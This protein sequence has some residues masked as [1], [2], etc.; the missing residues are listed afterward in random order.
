MIF[1]VSDLHLGREPDRDTAILSDLADC[2]STVS[3]DTVI[4]LGDV[5]DAF[6]ETPGRIP[7]PVHAWSGYVE[8]WLDE[9][10]DVRFVMGNHDRWHRE[11]IENLTGHT[12][13]RG[14]LDLDFGNHAVRL[15]HGD[16][17]EPHGPLTRFARWFSDLW[18][19]YRLFTLCMPFGGA[20]ALATHVSRKAGN[21]A[22]SPVTARAL[23][24][25]ARNLLTTHPIHG[26]LMGHAHL[27][28]IM[29]AE[30][31]TWYINTGNWYLGR[32]FVVLDAQGASLN[33]WREGGIRVLGKADLQN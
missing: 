27:H 4:F 23:E 18:I 3:P 11:W 6:V 5:F 31:G 30:D 12:P 15:E 14:H 17:G 7:A 25:Y 10:I 2:I 19:V 1:V 8:T 9:D 26:V 33:E 20:Q 32:T 13:V 24:A 28:G 16:A 22:S 29:P 21:P